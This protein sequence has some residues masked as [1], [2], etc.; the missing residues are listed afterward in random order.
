M[1]QQINILVVDDELEV[2]NFFNFLLCEKGYRVV[3]ACTGRDVAERL[4]KDSFYLAMVDLRLPDTDGIK[5]LEQI[6]AVQPECRV[7]IMTGYST[8]KTAVDAI[9]LG[10][11]DYIE[12]PFEELE[13]LEA[14]VE[15]AL[16]DALHQPA[17]E[18]NRIVEE[19]AGKGIVS[20]PESPFI[21]ILTLA[22]K[23]AGKN[24]NILIQGETGVGKEI[25]ARYIHTH[26]QR[27]HNPFIAVNCAAFTESLLESELFGHE[28]G[29]FTGAQGARKGI[30]QIANGG[31][32]FL[33]EIGDA[34]PTIQVKLLR[35]LE[36]GEYLPVG[37]EKFLK[38]DVRIIAATNIPL[39]EA[40]ATKKF[41]EDLF[42]RLNVVS[43]EIPPLRERTCDIEPM[44]YHF[45]Q[46]C[47]GS[48][49][50]ISIHPAAMELLLYYPWPG[51]VRELAN[52]MA[53]AM[54]FCEDG[55][56]T[57]DTLPD[58][59]KVHNGSPRGMEAL[60]KGK[61]VKEIV[62]QFSEIMA[63]QL[64]PFNIDLNEL[65]NLLKESQY[66]IARRIVENALAQAKGNRAN[67][68][69]R[70]N[71]TPRILRYYLNER[72]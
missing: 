38:T 67:A 59:I 36:N 35:V 34:S 12:K 6:K 27:S 53:R 9:K 66:T 40:V 23:I 44:A 65:I 72:G 71:S 47:H 31:T 13:E 20:S 64:L 52:M 17:R 16:S 69:K 45:A 46:K 28:R 54:V 32:L 8:V 68:A 51:N 57:P 70:I 4:A 19:L 22:Q 62:N 58:E 60:L 30:F 42:Y 3:N 21:K 7:V 41:R 63:K 43:L 26:C 2:G 37:G 11:Y 56:I 14:L 1:T 18:E 24:M 39:A 61:D 49:S 50:I 29:S 48:D 5:V 10:A 25:L 55:Q 15:S 33:D